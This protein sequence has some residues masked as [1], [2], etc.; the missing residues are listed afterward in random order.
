MNTIRKIVSNL[1][2]YSILSRNQS[3]ISLYSMIDFF[4][5]TRK[6]VFVLQV[7]ANDGKVN[8]PM[9]RFFQRPNWG[10][11]LLEPQR[12]VYEKELTKNYQGYT[13]VILEN[14]AIAPQSGTK[15]LYK[16]AFSSARWATGLSSF[17]KQSIL[18]LIHSGYVEK[19]AKSEGVLVPERIDDYITTEVVRCTSFKDLI[20]RHNISKIDILAIDTEGYDYEIIKMFDL[21]KM[22]PDMIVYENIHLNEADARACESYLIKHNYKVYLRGANSIALLKTPRNYLQ[23][24]LK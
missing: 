9:Y 2:K 8:D 1:S 6:S 12:D 18:N 14:A 7:G 23:L 4:S 24:L 19:C 13:N 20:S 3:L 5:A 10:G 17:E 11:V 15:E 21:N 16:I 22:K